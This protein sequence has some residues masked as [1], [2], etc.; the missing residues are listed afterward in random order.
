MLAQIPLA[1]FLFY[2]VNGQTM[3]N[4]VQQNRKTKRNG[5]DNAQTKCRKKYR[6]RKRDTGN[7]KMRNDHTEKIE[8]NP[9]RNIEKEQK[10]I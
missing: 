7:R 5:N 9:E 8:R 4:R 10:Y 2:F 3:G 1:L 6:N